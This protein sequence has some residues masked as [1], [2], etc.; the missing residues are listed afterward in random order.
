NHLIDDLSKLLVDISD[1]AHTLDQSAI[2]T[3]AQGQHM[4]VAAAQQLERIAEATSLA[5]NMLNNSQTVYQQADSTS[6]EIANASQFANDVN[7]IA[8]RNSQRIK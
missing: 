8:D 1:N 2:Q 5:Q 4:T 7:Q 6:N 3:S